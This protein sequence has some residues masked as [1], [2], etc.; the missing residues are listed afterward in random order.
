V[1][2]KMRAPGLRD[3]KMRD[4]KVCHQCQDEKGKAGNCGGLKCS[5]ENAI[6]EIN[7]GAKK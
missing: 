3:W 1:A 7:E 6:N 2:L 5:G 4:Q